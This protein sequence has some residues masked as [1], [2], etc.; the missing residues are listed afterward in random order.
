MNKEE[1][2]EILTKAKKL[3]DTLDPQQLTSYSEALTM[4]IEALKSVSKADNG[5]VKSAEEVLKTFP[6]VKI[7]LDDFYGYITTTRAMREYHNQ[8]PSAKVSDEEIEK[9]KSRLEAIESY[10]ARISNNLN[11]EV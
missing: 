10:L 1:A 2:I 7:G 11:K 8:F 4:A 9:I 6:S 3:R 5:E